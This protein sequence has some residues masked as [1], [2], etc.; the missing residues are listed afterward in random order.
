MVSLENGQKL[1][2]VILAVKEFTGIGS[3]GQYK[4]EKVWKRVDDLNV[5]PQQSEPPADRK[6]SGR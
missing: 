3:S 4:P 5:K 6:K 2:G 1:K